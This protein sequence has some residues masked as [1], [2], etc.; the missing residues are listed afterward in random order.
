MKTLRIALIS[1]IAGLPAAALAQIVPVTPG[2]PATPP[3]A[4]V[5]APPA[6]PRPIVI[7]IGADGLPVLQAEPSADTGFFYDDEVTGDEPEQ[8]VYEGQTPDVHVVRTGDTLWDICGYYFN[9]SWQWPKVWGYNAQIKDAHWIYPGDAVRLLPAGAGGA[10][11]AATDAGGATSTVAKTTGASTDS[12]VDA[13][14]AGTPGLPA[15]KFSISLRQT[16]FVSE[17]ELKTSMT[18]AGSNDD[19]TL[20]VSNDEVY[21]KYDPAEPP[22]VGKVYSIFEVAKRVKHPAT[23]KQAGAYVTVIGDVEI[24]SVRQDK[25]ARGYLRRT[26]GAIERGAKI[27]PLARQFKTVDPVVAKNDVQGV[28]VAMFSENELIGYGDVVFLDVGADSGLE[29]G[30]RMYVIRRGD[31][32]RTSLNH[33]GINDKRYPA[34]ILGELVVVETGKTFAVAVVT[35]TMEELGVSDIVVTKTG[36]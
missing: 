24:T 8:E 27:G 16:A 6:A 36:Q 14:A 30:N 19:K 5:A 26:T 4:P 18:I 3:A 11:G 31:M 34:R 12:D 23:G 1:L 10:G 20:M 25:F 32:L 33:A 2:V 7:P 17:E 9:D 29:V 21:V 22:T 13:I 15:K 28:I 35:L